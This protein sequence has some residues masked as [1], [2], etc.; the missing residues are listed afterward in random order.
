MSN[1]HKK[2]TNI[3]ISTPLKMVH[4]IKNSKMSLN[5]VEWI[6]IDEVDKFF[7]ESNQTFQQD[8]DVIFTECS[9][10]KRKFALFSATT[11][12]EMTAWVHEKLSSGF[13]TINIS[14][15]MPV[16][17][18]EQELR[19]VGTESSKIMELREIIRQGIQPPVLIFVQSKDRA[20]QLFSELM[21]DGLNIDIIHSDRTGK[22]RNEI[23]KK[24]REGKIWILICT[25]LMSRG[26]DFQ[27]VSLVINFDLPTSLISYVH[28]I[29]RAGRANKKGK[30]I[31]FYTNDDNKI[32]LLRDIAKLIKSSG[33]NVE[34]FLLQLKKSTKKERDA[35]LKK[36]PKRKKISTQI[37]SKSKKNKYGKK[38]KKVSKVED[39]ENSD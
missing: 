13:V 8:L 38:K 15:N 11:T 14:P 9:S 33:S 26:I 21:Y 1:F 20:K 5:K 22:E 7:E 25:E 12:K 32:G 30:A 18:V 16:S 17:S 31:T 3:L 6:V 39:D 23:Y 4:F 2:K 37:V 27:N 36:A 29:G 34:P 24:F 19:Y 35:L 28:K 10:P